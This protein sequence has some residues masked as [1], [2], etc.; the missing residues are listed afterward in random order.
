MTLAN[1][2][3]ISFQAK[4]DQTT[5]V[6]LTN[7]AYWNLAGA[8]C[9]TVLDHVLQ[10]FSDRYVVT[11]KDLLPTG[12]IAEVDNTPFDFRKPHS[13]G[14]RIK[15]TVIGGYDLCYLL[16][17]MTN[18]QPQFVAKI[19]EPISGRTLEVSTTQPGLQFYIGNSLRDYPIS[20]G[21][22]TQRYGGFCMET[23]NFPGA[24]NFV[25]FPSPFLLPGDIYQH[26][27]VY[28]LIW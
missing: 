7:H 28:R 6:D 23:Q 5:P 2:L 11:D 24:V 10:I 16:P 13:I 18:H 17:P 15:D 22:N 25:Q 9:G 1:E 20:S 21:L 26:E 4:T 19:K 8:G 3:K 14:E 12:Q 27:T